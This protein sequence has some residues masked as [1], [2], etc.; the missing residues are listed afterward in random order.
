MRRLFVALTA[1]LISAPAAIAVAAI[2][3]PEEHRHAQSGD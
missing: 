2:D 1:A 3:L